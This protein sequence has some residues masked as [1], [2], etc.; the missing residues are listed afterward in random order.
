MNTVG[1]ITEYNPFH[2]GHLYHIN[3]SKEISNSDVVICIM[4]GNFVQR[5]EAAMLDKWTRTKMA[6]AN[7]VDLVIELPLL[8][9][10]RSAEYFAKGAI[11]LLHYS[12]IVDNIVFGSEVGNIT[13]LQET[14]NLLL[15]KD[16]F[17]QINLHK[18]LGQ[19][20]PFPAARALAIENYLKTN[21]QKIK[22]D[23]KEIL[24]IIGEPNNILGIEYIK[25]IKKLQTDITPFTIQRIGSNYHD[26]TL[27]NKIASATAIRNQFYNNNINKIKKYLP[28]EC[29]NI[30][31]EEYQ[32]DKI[33]INLD[34][35]GMMLFSTLRKLNKTR[36][37]RY[38]ELENG[39]D[40]RVL[41]EVHKS[42]DINDLIKNIKTKAYTQTRIQRNLLHIFFD[43]TEDDFKLIDIFGPQYIRVLGV[44]K[45]KIEILSAINKNSSL[46]VI[47]NP[48]EY[49]NEIDTES[50]NPLIKSLSYDILAT[51][52]YSLLYKDPTFRQGHRDFT[53]P[54]IKY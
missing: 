19:G 36:M 54:L 25:A 5:G 37:G 43:I 15:K 4:N 26:K 13:P 7:N 9:G 30:I 38:A 8:Y 42:G 24:D 40:N 27:S 47:I 32:N 12:G 44:R 21:S 20:E 1:I 10:I 48:S 51:D 53:T 22:S 50:K 11:S 29:Q 3:K 18:Y 34:N 28:E 45:E 33:P 14:A 17:F 46:E 52:I 2:Y 39:L 41:N 6:L 49:L 16:P 35:F 31:N 23:K